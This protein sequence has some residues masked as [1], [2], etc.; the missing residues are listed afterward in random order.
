M[1]GIVYL[2]GA[3]PG[4]PGLLTL[5]GKALLE[6]ADCVV[7]DFLANEELLRDTR[8]DCRKIYAGK[9]AGRHTMTQERINRLLMD[10]ARLGETVVRL[11]GG[12]PFIFGR[13]GEEAMTLAEAGIPFQV[14]P[15]VSSG[16]AAPAYAGIPLTHRDVASSVSFLTAHGEDTLIPA[17]ISLPSSETLVFFMGARNLAELTAALVRQGRSPSTPAAVIRW[18]T[19]P[20]QEVITGT[21]SDIAVRAG[22]L[23]PPTVAVIGKVVTLREQ[24]NWFER[25][26]LFGKRILVT[27]PRE[28]A[29]S[30]REALAERGAQPVEL[31]TL[32]IR[33]PE[34]WEPLDGAIRR[35]DRFDFL[36]VTSVNGVRKFLARLSAAGRDVR[37]LK[38]IEIGAIGPAT[39][40]EFTVHGVRVD[41]VPCEYRAEGML[42]ALEGRDLK[43]KSFLIPRARVARDFVPRVLVERGAQ[44]EVIETY[45][46][47]APDYKAE[48]LEALLTPLPDV[49]TFTSSS[50]ALNFNKLPLR[51]E[52]RAKLAKATVASLGPITS[53]TL[54]ELGIKVDVEARES[55]TA[56]LV[57]ALEN[58]FLQG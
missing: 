53:A 56:G 22:K 12:D 20:D 58:Y 39:A 32:E 23:A 45:Y 49:L 44:V 29:V 57:Q 28:Q 2:V 36:L 11:K 6:R 10:H 3:G 41:F 33:D 8:L 42:Q 18:G 9:R 52:M 24:L 50:T 47:A 5:K 48:E 4:D 19:T 31:P 46:A 37:R 43:G 25:L 30:L 1:P 17:S 21:L 26:P 51:E 55:I 35:L 40:A 13:G 27:R 14:V 16:H 15:G 34:S 38:G 7:Y 54:R